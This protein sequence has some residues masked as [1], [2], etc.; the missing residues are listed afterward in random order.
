GQWVQ[1]QV[2]ASQLGLEGAN[3][4]G[5]TFTTYNGRATFDHAGKVSAA[6]TNSGPP[7]VSTNTP[8]TNPPPVISDPPTNSTPPPTNPAPVIST[9][10]LP[11]LS[12][13]DYATLALPPVG[14][15]SLKVLAPTILQ[16]TLI[17]TKPSPTAAPSA[18][19]LVDSS[20]NFKNPGT[21]AFT[22]LVN[23]QTVG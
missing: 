5:M 17:N 4:S 21:G 16:L 9:N 18:W 15:N 22:V 8:A 23:G 19:D 13:S 11:G 20:G 3:L 2:P 10:G 14:T 6:V 7:V 12:I 1:L